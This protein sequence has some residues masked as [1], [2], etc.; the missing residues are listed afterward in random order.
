MNCA[1]VI[2][3]EPFPRYCGLPVHAHP[4]ARHFRFCLSH[5]K[6]YLKDF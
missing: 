1:C 3:V 2:P 5:A 6:A 4:R